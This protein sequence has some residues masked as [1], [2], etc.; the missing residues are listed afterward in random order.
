MRKA[1]EE[2]AAETER[3][4]WA[5]LEGRL[6]Q[7]YARMRENAMTIDTDVS[8]ALRARLR[9]ASRTA[10]EDWSRK[11]GPEGRALLERR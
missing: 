3:R 2:A 5:A 8:P 10:V 4:Q 1:I 7:N 6:V 9:E 11:A